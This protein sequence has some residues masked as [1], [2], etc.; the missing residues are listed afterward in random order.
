[1]DGRRSRYLAS[2]WV[3]LSL[4]GIATQLGEMPTLINYTLVTHYNQWSPFYIGLIYLM[5]LV[6]FRVLKRKKKQNKEKT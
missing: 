1:M 4:F 6:M 3:S 2:L 5:S